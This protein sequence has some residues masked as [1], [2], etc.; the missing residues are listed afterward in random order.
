MPHNRDAT[1]RKDADALT[2]KNKVELRI[3]GKDYTVVGTEPAEYILRVGH[4]IDR[5]MTEVM[6]VSSKLSTSL[7]AVLT[8]VNIGDDFLKCQESE[9]N[10]KKELKKAHEEIEKLRTDKER[11]SQ[12]IASLGGINTSIKLEL[13]KREAEL[14]EVRNSLDKASR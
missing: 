13:A 5:K 8:A 1:C 10:L 6:R 7:A 9:L 14:G 12:E 3:A 11:L 2:A 4:Y